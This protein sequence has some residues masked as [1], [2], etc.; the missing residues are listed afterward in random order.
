MNKVDIKRVV[1]KLFLAWLVTKM[2]VLVGCKK[3][4]MPAPQPTPDPIEIPND[5][6]SN[7]TNNVVGDT[8]IH[9]GG[10]KTIKFVYRGGEDYPSKDS[11]IKYANDPDYD[12]IYIKWMNPNSD[13]GSPYY[14]SCVGKKFRELFGVS[15]KVDGAGI[16]RV[17]EIR[18][19]CD[20]VNPYVL[21]ISDSVARVFRDEWHYPL[22]VQ[23]EG[24]KNANNNP[25]VGSAVIEDKRMRAMND[26]RRYWS[27]NLGRK[28][29]SNQ[30]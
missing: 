13:R 27:N 14:F 23:H 2:A 20:S 3:E 30:Y 6:S 21:G 18:Q 29:T 8:T 22:Y 25:G 19:D 9:H 5:S 4:P 11:I 24:G 28:M 26:Q 12:T 1:P 16:I 15:P 7:D 10:G 17:Y